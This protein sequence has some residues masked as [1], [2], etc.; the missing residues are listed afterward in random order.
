[1]SLGRIHRGPVAQYRRG[2]AWPGSASACAAC[3]AHGLAQLGTVRARMT[4]CGRLSGAARVL[5][6]GDITGAREA[7]RG[8]ARR[9][10]TG[11]WM[12]ARPSSRCR[13]WRA[14]STAAHRWHSDAA[15]VTTPRRTEWSR[16]RR[17]LDGVDGEA[18][19]AARARAARRRPV[20]RRPGNGG[21]AL[22]Q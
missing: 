14:D 17:L 13:R 8:R 6:S 20:R 2:P 18:W 5:C 21:G 9:G 16:R 19:T 4:Q 15:K 22:R 12:A 7:V 3:V 11:A 1:L 10:L